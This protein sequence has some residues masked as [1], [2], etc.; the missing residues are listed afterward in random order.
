M[1][2]NF[3]SG[4]Q[5]PSSRRYLESLQESLRYDAFRSMERLLQLSLRAELECFE[6]GSRKPRR[7]R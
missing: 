4:R 6:V 5:P 2:G 3:M 7:M 1:Q